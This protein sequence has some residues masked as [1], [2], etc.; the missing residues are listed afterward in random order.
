M[1]KINLLPWREELRQEQTRQFATITVLSLILTGALIFLVH[2]SF[3][4][5]IDYED[6]IAGQ[7]TEY[8][9]PEIDETSPMGLCYTSGTTGKPKGAMLSYHNITKNAKAMAE[10]S[11]DLRVFSSTYLNHSMPSSFSSWI[12]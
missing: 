5:Q 12:P 3:E 2:V 11:M 8:E 10:P 1:A 6:F 9:W 7:A 4:N